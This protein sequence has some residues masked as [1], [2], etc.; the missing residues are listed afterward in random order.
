M[1]YV[2]ERA[3]VTE[4]SVTLEDDKQPLHAP[5]N[6]GCLE[7]LALLRPEITKARVT[8]LSGK[9]ILSSSLWKHK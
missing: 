5:R 7:G 1:I 9:V 2:V 4:E 3:Q 8:A 6:F